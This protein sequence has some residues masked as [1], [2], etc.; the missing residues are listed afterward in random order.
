MDLM[1]SVRF[2]SLFHLTSTIARFEVHLN[3]TPMGTTV[4]SPAWSPGF[5]YNKPSSLVIGSVP[6][7][8]SGI[9]T[10][11]VPCPSLPS[12]HMVGRNFGEHTLIKGSNLL[13]S[14]EVGHNGDPDISYLTME[15]GR[16]ELLFTEFV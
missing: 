12:A 13:L 5:C 14:A 7:S 1:T 15:V 4:S 9:S 3:T 8:D 10:A 6:T 11:A 16:M 2:Q